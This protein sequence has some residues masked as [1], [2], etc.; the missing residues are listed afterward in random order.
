MTLGDKRLGFTIVLYFCEKNFSRVH[1][2]STLRACMYNNL[3]LYMHI[4]HVIFHPSLQHFMKVNR[5]VQLL[6]QVL[7]S[8]KLPIG[9]PE[10]S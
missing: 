5:F 3:V 8:V 7:R 9:E 10:L 4:L 6:S 1:H 2:S